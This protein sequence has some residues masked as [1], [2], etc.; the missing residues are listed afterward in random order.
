MLKLYPN[1]VN[2]VVR[3]PLLV[4]LLSE[5]Q[6]GWAQ[7]M[8]E[9]GYDVLHVTY[10]DLTLESLNNALRDTTNRIASADY[11]DWGL[12][13]YGLRETDLRYVA[14]LFAAPGLKACVHYCAQLEQ[15]QSLIVRDHESE[16]ILPTIFH[17]ASSQELL[18]ASLIPW[19]DTRALGYTLPTSSFPPVSVYT[20]PLVSAKPPFPY[21]AKAP[22][23]VRP[24]EAQSVDLYVRSAT[25]LAYTRTLDLLKR[26]LGPHYNFEK[27]WEQH[28][29]YEFAERNAL[30]T[31]STMVSTPYVNHIATLTGGLGFDELARFYKYHFTSDKVTPPDTELIP[32]SRT[33]GADR[34]VD[35][36]VFKCTHTTEID[37]FLPGVAPTGKPLEIALVGIVAFRGDKLTFEYW[38]QAS[39]LVQQLDLLD[40]TNLPVAGVEV[41]R[42][43]VDPFGLPSNSLMKRWQESEGLPL[44]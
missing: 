36:M 43:M 21:M 10:P 5:E 16:K 30:K 1:A 3:P 8:S 27:L 12:I 26:E 40:P 28:T 7:Q 11:T 24:G 32:I 41:A 34:I 25:G 18:H 17:L 6:A 33:I 2:S 38:D 23:L 31:M 44:E 29:Y 14:E 39:V 20:Y 37:Y 35:E 19:T 9:E 4:L 15:A 13:T 22:T 42:K